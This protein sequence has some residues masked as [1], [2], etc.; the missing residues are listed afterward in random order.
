MKPGPPK[1]PTQLRILKGN[2]GRRPINDKE[3]KP[4]PRKRLPPPPA[5][6][7]V[8]GRREWRRISKILRDLKLLNDADRTAMHAYCDAYQRW[9]RAN[10]EYDR[11][12][13]ENIGRGLWVQNKTG[14]LSAHPV[15]ATRDKLSAEL[16][17]YLNEFGLTPSARTGLSV[18]TPEETSEQVRDRWLRSS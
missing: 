2:P 1:Q 17:R 3:P 6:L 15:V 9:Y 12:E 14:G 8:D 7:G 4:E 10:R 16:R 13:R 11:I 18:S 5:Q